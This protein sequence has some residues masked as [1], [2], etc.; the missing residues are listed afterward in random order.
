MP[1]GPM[2]LETSK[3]IETIDVKEMDRQIDRQLCKILDIRR[4]N[5]CILGMQLGT[6]IYTYS[7]CRQIDKLCRQIDTRIIKIMSSHRF[8]CEKIN[9]SVFDKKHVMRLD[10]LHFWPI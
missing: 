7:I 3:F 5:T 9:K 10:K 2:L 4:T 8:E 1:S 6:G